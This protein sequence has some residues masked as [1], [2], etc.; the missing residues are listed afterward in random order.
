MIRMPRKDG[1]AYIPNNV[2]EA[3]YKSKSLTS[4]ENSVLFFIMMFQFR[5]PISNIES[6]YPITI[7]RIEKE[8]KKRH[9]AFRSGGV[10]KYINAL[11]SKKVLIETENGVIINTDTNQWI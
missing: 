3:M 2:M 6:K 7:E 1:T 8:T 11:I 5:R 4:H 10:K 9:Y